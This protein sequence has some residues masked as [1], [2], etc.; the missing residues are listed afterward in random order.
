MTRHAGGPAGVLRAL[1]SAAL[2][3]AVVPL[4]AGDVRVVVAAP[5]SQTAQR[6][7]GV[8]TDNVCPD[9]DHS[10]MKMGPTDA[11]CTL[12]CIDSHGA[13][14][15]LYD[16]HTSYTLSDQQTPARFA[17]RKVIVTGTLDA[18]LK[19]IQVETIAAASENQ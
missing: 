1:L 6:F 16:G 4:V 12:A 7:T 11:E 8:V 5:A 3:V 9:G 17:G 18:E 2:C 13:T 14:Y 10:S 19:T 15:V